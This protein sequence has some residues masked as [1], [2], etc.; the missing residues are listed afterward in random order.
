[1]IIRKQEL[2]WQTLFAGIA[3]G[4]LKDIAHFAWGALWQI[5]TDAML[6]AEKQWIKSGSGEVKKDWVMNQVMA[7]LTKTKKLNFLS[8]WIVKTFLS[9]VIDQFITELNRDFENHE[10]AKHVQDLRKYIEKYLPE[11]VR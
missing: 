11:Y 2:M 6:E 8:K 4:I 1:M 3:I 9:K 10:W 5:I 7:Y